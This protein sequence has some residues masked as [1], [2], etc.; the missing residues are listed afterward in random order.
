MRLFAFAATFVCALLASP[1]AHAEVTSSS[2]SAFLL[3]AEAETS[4]S[5]EEAWRALSRLNRWWNSEHTYSGDARRMSV[6]LRAGGCWCERWDGQS[7]E[8]G[9]VVLVMEHEGVR[10]LRF[11]T[12]LGPLQELGASGVLTFTI[13]PHASGAKIIMTYRVAGDAGL[14]LD[15]I[16]PLVDTVV[17]EQFGRLERFSTSGSAN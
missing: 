9:R 11:D 12:A 8:H 3:R 13:A 15:R 2:P 16:A 7:V 17:M 14:G 10:T 6:D 5:P 1:L 4:A